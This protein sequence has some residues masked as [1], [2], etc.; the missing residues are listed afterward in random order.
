MTVVGDEPGT[1]QLGLRLALWW[2]VLVV[3]F[4]ALAVQAARE[5]P[6]RETVATQ[7]PLQRTP[8]CGA[9]DITTDE[10]AHE[11]ARRRLSSLTF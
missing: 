4:F 8:L 2:S 1:L 11:L 6:G 9:D 5:E 10:L 7:T 3:F